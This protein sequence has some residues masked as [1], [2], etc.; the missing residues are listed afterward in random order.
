MPFG[1]FALAPGISQLV[2]A[3]AA[4]WMSTG[5]FAIAASRLAA[6]EV[7]AAT[8]RATDAAT[9]GGTSAASAWIAVRSGVP[10]RAVISAATASTSGCEPPTGAT[11]EPWPVHPIVIARGDERG[12]HAIARSRGGLQRTDVGAHER[13]EVPRLAL[14]RVVVARAI[15]IVDL[16]GREAP[17]GTRILV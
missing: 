2:T 7:T 8:S 15:E 10:P 13:H 11:A 5:T 17:T 4:A 1:K 6:E 12:T 14:E 9:A 3:Y 16:G